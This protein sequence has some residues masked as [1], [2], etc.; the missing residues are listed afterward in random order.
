[1]KILFPAG[2]KESGM[3]SGVSRL[4]GYAKSFLIYDTDDLN[5][6]NLDNAY[7]DGN[8][9][10][11]AKD[12]VE[13]GVTD[14]ITPRICRNCY[15]DFKKAGIEIW[16]DDDSLSIREAYQK[17]LLGGIFL[18]SEGDHNTCPNHISADEKC[19]FE[20]LALDKY[21]VDHKIKED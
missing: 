1:M 20:E 2:N 15:A 17:F 18:M 5:F 3:K 21:K 9:D 12:L 4:L 16:R 11:L 8:N 7:Y 19:E 14:I 10:N 13:L 6:I